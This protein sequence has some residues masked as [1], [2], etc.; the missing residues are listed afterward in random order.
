MKIT[1]HA[2]VILV[3]TPTAMMAVLCLSAHSVSEEVV[4]FVITT[5]PVSSHLGG[6][7]NNESLHACQTP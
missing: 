1:P 4:P 5:R 7:I 2:T 6:Q 3:V